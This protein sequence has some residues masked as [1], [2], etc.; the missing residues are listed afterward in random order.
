M[1]F[2]TNTNRSKVSREVNVVAHEL[3]KMSRLQNRTDVWLSSFPQDV[4]VSIATDC[5]STLF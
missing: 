1:K 4:A 5:N 2:C 3:A